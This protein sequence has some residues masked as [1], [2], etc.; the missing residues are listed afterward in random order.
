MLILSTIK[1]LSHIFSYYGECHCP[2]SDR[3]RLTKEVA[4]AGAGLGRVSF[5]S[6]LSRSLFVV[7]NLFLLS[8]FMCCHSNPE[9]L[10]QFSQNKHYH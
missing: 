3:I 9:S 6:G 4:G 1:I 8:E 5:S 2:T 7:C 10:N